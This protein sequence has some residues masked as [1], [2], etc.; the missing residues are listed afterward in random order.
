MIKSIKMTGTCASAV[1]VDVTDGIIKSISFNGGCDGNLQGISRL[2]AGM[3]AD[4][5]IKKLEGI[6]C[7]KKD[8]SCPDQ[9]A[10]ALKVAEHI[11]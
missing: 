8:T 4:D 1:Y 7:G 2:V 3:H 10:H 9:L 11:N 5:V 6:K